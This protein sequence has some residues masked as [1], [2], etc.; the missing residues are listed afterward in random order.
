MIGPNGIHQKD[1][2]HQ[3]TKVLRQLGMWKDNVLVAHIATRIYGRRVTP[4]YVGLLNWCGGGQVRCLGKCKVR[5]Q[6]VNGA[7]RELVRVLKAA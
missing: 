4:Q 5:N 7:I 3:A 1:A 6:R 2:I